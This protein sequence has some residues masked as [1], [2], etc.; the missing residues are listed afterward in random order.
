[1]EIVIKGFKV[2]IDQ[3]DYEKIMGY[4]WTIYKV[5]DGGIHIRACIKGTKPQKNI[6]LWRLITNCPDE[7][8]VDHR[9]HNRFDNRK[10][11]LRVCTAM[12]NS[13]NKLNRIDNTSGCKGVYWNKR[14]KKWHAQIGVNG[15][16]KHI[17]FF[18]SKENAYKEY[19]KFA[20][21]YFKEY[22]PEIL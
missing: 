20:E 5:A 6:L 12:Q 15:K 9:N 1:M 8:Q 7:L 3:E 11:N 10:S 19:R 21:L 18:D 14:A 2:L 22:V 4:S 17:G 16:R 13:R